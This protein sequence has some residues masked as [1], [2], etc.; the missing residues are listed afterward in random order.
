MSNENSNIFDCF[1]NPPFEDSQRLKKL[2]PLLFAGMIVY[3]VLLI[4]EIFFFDGTSSTNYIFIL[5]FLSLFIFLKYHQLFGFY[6]FISIYQCFS[7]ILPR[8]GLIIQ[9]GFEIILDH[10]H[11]IIEF[12]LNF[13]I[14]C[15]SVI[16]FLI[17]FDAFKEIKAL[18]N[19]GNYPYLSNLSNENNNNDNI[20]NLY[21][22]ETKEGKEKKNKGFKAFSG[23]G[24]VVGGN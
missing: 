3:L 20:N 6:V 7:V 9:T 12:I 10:R 8:F 11:P 13:F 4:L 24:H 23:K 17:T 18:G 1:G 21:P 19:A 16:Y 15:F 2:K 5:C 22:N 14:L